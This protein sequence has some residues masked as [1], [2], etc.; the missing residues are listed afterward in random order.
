MAL[1]AQQLSD[2]EYAQAMDAARNASVFSTQRKNHKLEL[3]RL[4]RDVLIENSRSK[5]VDARDVTAEAI[6]TFADTLIDYIDA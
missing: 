3:V 5:P 4:A 2:I 6:I 1:T